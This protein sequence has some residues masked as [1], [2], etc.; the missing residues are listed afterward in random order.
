MAPQNTKTKRK[1]PSQKSEPS[2]CYSIMTEVFYLRKI[3]R[4]RL[5][6]ITKSFFKQQYHLFS[7]S[8]VKEKTH[9]LTENNSGGG[10]V[11]GKWV[12]LPPLSSSINVV[13]LGKRISH[14]SIVGDIDSIETMTS[15]LKWVNR[16]C[17]HLPRSLVQK[18]FR[19][20]QV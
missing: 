11:K 17:P 20:R 8:I 2:I 14:L 18:L 4:L 3:L 16:C 15:A 9:Q 5:S 13:S 1:K 7:T 12:T 19:L 6:A 10:R